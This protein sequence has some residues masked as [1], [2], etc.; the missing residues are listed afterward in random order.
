MGAS[1]S[2]ALCTSSLAVLGQVPRGL[3]GFKHHPSQRN[4]LHYLLAQ[5]PGTLDL[6]KRSLLRL[7]SPPISG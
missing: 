1:A 6:V 2:C 4:N 3:Q 7:T 5:G